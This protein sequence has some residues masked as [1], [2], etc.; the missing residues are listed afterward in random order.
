M[1][2][3]IIQFF[4]DKKLFVISVGE[5]S[6]I[7]IWNS[8]G[9]LIHKKFA[10]NG[11]TI[12]NIDYDYSTQTVFTCGSNGNINKFYIGNILDSNLKIHEKF[13]DYQESFSKLRFVDDLIAI[14]SSNKLLVYKDER[15]FIEYT[16]ERLQCSLLEAQKNQIYVI[17]KSVIKIFEYDD[18]IELKSEKSLDF[19]LENKTLSLIRS[20][21]YVSDDKILVCNNHGKCLLVNNKSFDPEKTFIIPQCAERWITSVCY[22]N[23]ELILIGDRCGSLHL[24]DINI[25]NPISTLKRLHGNLGITNILQNEEDEN[26]IYFTTS[27]H[28]GTLK[29]VQMNKSNKKL[30]LFN[31]SKIPVAWIEKM[32]KIDNMSFIFGFNDKHFVVFEKTEGIVFQFNCGGGHRFWHVQIDENS[33]IAKFIYLQNKKVASIDFELI[34]N[35]KNTVNV[36]SIDWHIKSCNSVNIISNSYNQFFI[37]GGEDN[38]IKI[39]HFGKLNNNFTICS[40]VLS[41]ISSIKCVRTKTLPN[42]D[43]LVFSVG[44]RAQLCITRIINGKDVRYRD[45]FSYMLYQTDE[46]R[47]RKQRSKVQEISFDPETRFMCISFYE[48]DKIV[49][50]CS[51]GYIRFYNLIL[52]DDDSSFC[53]QPYMQIFYGKCILNVHCFKIDSQTLLLTMGTDGF[54]CFWNLKDENLSSVTKPIHKLKHHDSGV[55]CFDLNINK[56]I[57]YIATGGDDQKVA[58]TEFEVISSDSFVNVKIKKTVTNNS[59]HTAQVT[60]IKIVDGLFILSTGVDQNICKINLDSFKIENCYSS[61]I[62]DIKGL[63]ISEDKKLFVY[64]SGI[65]F[66]NIL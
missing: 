29:E 46:Q 18:K 37:S 43:I 2:A 32:K 22:V 14:T 24:Y 26:S 21:S 38:L 55:N 40:N 35:C 51:D 23:D 31:T 42:N 48:D 58:L 64:G 56:N 39:G 53:I 19:Q 16:A 65:E 61:C 44:G 63:V 30:I 17:D 25:E 3:L 15:N 50:G 62:S 28:D 8:I 54:I 1:F 57:G 59:S 33:K 13:I 7:C 52:N 36:R 27:G 47:C 4:S 20:L 9:T 49:I 60:G 41:H 6:N 12:W 66:L 34:Q 11:A 5:D 45:E 10:H